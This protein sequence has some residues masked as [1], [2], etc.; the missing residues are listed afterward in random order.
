LDVEMRDHEERTVDVAVIGAGTAGLAAFRAA[1]AKGADALLIEA[2]PHGT[3]CA[4]V[5]CM[6]S[7]LLI[8]AGDVAF[9]A[10]HA[11][12]FGVTARV[13]VDGR[14]VMDRVRRERDRFV[15]FVLEG[16]RAIPPEHHLAG[17]ARFVSPGE[18]D[19]DGVRVRT[20]TVVVATGSSPV[21][22]PMFERIRDRLVVNDH[23]FGW[24]DLPPSLAVFGAGV[25]GL[26]LGQ[27]L[28]RLGVRVR[29]FGLG[30]GVGPLA[31][32]VVTAVAAEAFR[33]ELR[34]D[35]DA[36]VSA[37]EPEGD[38]VVVRFV[39]A[40]G[41]PRVER[42]ASALV[43]AGRRP[44][45]AS[46]AIENAGIAEGATVDRTT[47]Q[48][49]TS[50]VFRAG[51]ANDDLPILHEAADEGGIAGVNA[52]R[53]PEVRPG[54]RRTPLVVAFTEPGLAVV[55]GGWRA[56]AN[57]P[58]AAGHVDFCDQGRSRILLQ[59]QGAARLYAEP[60]SRRFLGA[61]IVG[62]RAEHLAHLLAWA[63]Q[64]GLTVEQMLSMPFYHPV[65]EEGLR[66]ALRDLARQLDTALARNE[67]R[68]RTR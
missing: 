17:H 63:H 68:G 37:V 52:A 8:A 10:T 42:F 66:T 44:N 47:M 50:N 35:F 6:P 12:P 59:N 5:G 49:G 16:V 36:K 62:P 32:P 41:E 64:A 27:A 26:E 57:R 30:G 45:V 40:D 25:I 18:L 61:E 58:H 43:A 1:Q 31:D 67:E 28:E 39:G 19:V 60:G 65:I 9:H 46:L 14:A 22:P 34:V 15:G 33:R 3:T 4:R 54:K 51:D 56:V 38:G 21:I 48:W 13:S 24:D 2:G 29:V 20:K 23:V 7:K 53:Y 55:A 11:Q